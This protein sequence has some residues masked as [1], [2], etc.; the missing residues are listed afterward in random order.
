M[1]VPLARTG[2]GKATA[3]TTAGQSSEKSKTKRV[4]RRNGNVNML[5]GV[6]LHGKKESS[7]MVAAICRS[8]DEERLPRQTSLRDEDMER[9][10]VKIDNLPN[11]KEKAEDGD[12]KRTKVAKQRKKCGRT[13]TLNG[14]VDQYDV[15]CKIGKTNA[16][17]SNGQLLRGD[18][19]DA[20]VRAKK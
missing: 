17:V 1:T 9:T 3:K 15:D 8:R 16:G 11:S 5:H 14:R 7:E 13:E 18:A 10:S 4:T 2:K 19:K 20:V 6:Y 12:K